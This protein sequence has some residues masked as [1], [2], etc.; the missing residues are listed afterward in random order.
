MGELTATLA[1]EVNQPIAAALTDANTCIRWLN[2]DQPDL[3]EAHQAASRMAKDATRAAEIVSRIRALFKKG[4]QQRELV[5]VNEL[6]RE[7]MVMLRGEAAR[8]SIALR[9]NL[10]A[11]L[12]QV[13]GDRVQLQQ[14]LMNLIMN[15]IDAMNDAEGIRELTVTS[16]HNNGDEH[17]SHGGRLWAGANSPRGAIIRLTLPTKAEVHE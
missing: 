17:E 3:E 6:V 15:S 11:D 5:D 14:V 12:P 2:R 10:A 1:H 13:M 9:T 7:M 8:Y 16:Q 4:V